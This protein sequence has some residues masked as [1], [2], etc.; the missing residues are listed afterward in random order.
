[1]AGMT[2]IGKAVEDYLALRRV[3]GFAQ[4][5]DVPQLR[6]FARFMDE[7]GASHITVDLA[8]RWAR[9]SSA[10][11]DRWATR[12]SWIRRLARHL[13]AS[14]GKTEVPPLG[15]LPPCRRRRV[16]PYLYTTTEIRKLIEAAR[17]LTSRTGVRPIVYSTLIG[18]LAVTGLRRGDCSG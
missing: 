4:K 3:L 8:L 14:D 10:G 16:Q 17:G 15:L 12:L 18:L 11:P 5:Q 2:A 1:M 6:H 7:N 13:S 9:L